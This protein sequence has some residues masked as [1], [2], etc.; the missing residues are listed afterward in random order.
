MSARKP[1]KQKEETADDKFIALVRAA[2]ENE[3]Q[4]DNMAKMEAKERNV[5]FG[6]CIKFIAVIRR[7]GDDDGG[8]WFDGD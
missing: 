4:E 6:N 8:S 2:M 5:L 3:L 7:R 1:E